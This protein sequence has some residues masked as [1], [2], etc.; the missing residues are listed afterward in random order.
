MP[1]LLFSPIKLRALELSNRIVVAPMCQYSA[2]HG[3]ATDWHLMHLGQYAVSGVGLVFVE[4]TGVEPEGRITPGCVGLYNDENEAALA[5]VIKFYRDYGSAKI[6]IQLGHA[7]RK[8]SAKLPWQGG[9]A[10]TADEGAW[11]TVAP[12]A[13]PYGPGWHTPEALGDNALARVK[14][15]FVQATERALR[16]D[17]DAIEIHSAH[18]YLLHAFLSPISNQRDDAY[19]GSLENRMRFPLEVFDAVRAIWP[20]DRPLGVRFSATDWIGGGWDLASSI[21]YAEALKAR[22]CDFFDVSS[23]GLAPQQQINS[24]PGYQT[25]FAADVRRATG[26]TTMAVGRITEPHQA[27]TILQTGQADMIALARGMLYDPRWPWH[28]AAELRSDAAFPAQY[29]RSHPSMQ[30]EPVPGN[31]PVPKT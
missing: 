13:I 22:G 25:A 5:R 17:F 10:L 20:E 16:L 12:S 1:S 28:A 26:I 9:T 31:P 8:A 27:E 14:Q 7:G 24:A 23:G 21:A 18:G 15:A 6:G 4:A 2:H 11:Q 3:S 19:G 30:G 29:A